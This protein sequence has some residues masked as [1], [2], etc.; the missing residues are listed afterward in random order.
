M[1]KNLMK[2]KLGQGAAAFG[3]VIQEP[4]IQ[5]AE[6]LALIGFDYLFIDC[7][8]SPMSY[9]S[10]AQLAMAAE[11]RGIT[12]LVRV[13]RNAPD[14]ILRC[15]DVG[16][17]GVV[18][19]D[20]TSAADAARAV[21]AAKYPPEGERGLA[22]VRVADFGLR[23]P[24]GTYVKKANAETMVLGCVESR[25]GVEKIE[26]ILQTEGLD[27]VFIGAN[28]LSKSLGVAGQTSHPLVLEAAGKVLAAGRKTGKAVGSALRSGETPKQYVEQGYRLL[29]TTVSALLAVGGKQFFANV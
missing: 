20:L 21:R 4:A 23:E 18:I 7:E 17:I 6:V 26:E 9:E 27:G 16:T 15:M 3:V 29:S 24:L 10:V 11:L 28:D 14:A 1:H 13:P 5:V 22:G 25:G 19:P 12:P 2:E 8:H